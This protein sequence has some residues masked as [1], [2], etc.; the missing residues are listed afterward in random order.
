MTLLSAANP[1]P[2]EPLLA[3][4]EPPVFEVAN[5]AGRG[6]LVLTCDHASNRMPARLG[7]LG[8]GAA[9]L[10]SHIAWDPGAAW[11]ARRLSVLL[12]APLVLSGYS[13]LVVDCNRPPGVPGSIPA[14]SAGVPVPGNQDLSE[15]ERRQRFDMLLTPYQAAIG[16]LLE[17]RA[18][19]KVPTVVLAIHSFTP[20]YPGQERPWPIAV[21]HRHDGGLARPLI[22][23]LRRDPAALPVGDNQ[24]YVIGDDSDYTIPVQAER[25]RLPNA[26]I[27]IRQDGLRSEADAHR[28][29]GRL[30]DAVSPILPALARI[31]T[32]SETPT[33]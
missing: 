19:A 30:A 28:W 11:V 12:D 25:R 5:A 17:W 1:A 13:R 4:D 16:H 18:A 15:A 31:P 27:E 29:A 14:A 32:P 23:R 8:L 22:E 10:A 2:P 21:T 3:E 24:P 9:D 7:T 6:A 26:L 20:D 33:P